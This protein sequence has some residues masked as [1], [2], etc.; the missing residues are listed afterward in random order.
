MGTD[1]VLNDIK[2]LSYNYKDSNIYIII[3]SK[4]SK[5]FPDA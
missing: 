5:E 4:I 1:H 2:G 3:P